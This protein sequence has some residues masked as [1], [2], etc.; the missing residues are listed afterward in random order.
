MKQSLTAADIAIAVRTAPRSRPTLPMTLASIRKAGFAQRLH[1]FAEPQARVSRDDGIRVVRRKRVHGIIGNWLVSAQEMEAL[2]SA[3]ILMMEDDVYMAPCAA[4]SLICGID[5]CKS[6]RLGYFS[7]F[8]PRMNVVRLRGPRSGW[9]PF[10]PSSATWGALA[11]CFP[12]SSLRLLLR[13]RKL[14]SAFDQR[15]GL[16]RVVGHVLGSR[17][18]VCFQHIPSL[19]KHIGYESTV[20]HAQRFGMQAVG[21]SD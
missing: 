7:L 15:D 12:A 19:S 16:D 13:S 21:W 1:V 2:G 4:S 5:E 6:D 20:N 14:W 17:R 11:W 8:T 3:Y 10:R 18:M 9:V